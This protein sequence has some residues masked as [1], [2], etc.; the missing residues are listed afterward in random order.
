MFECFYYDD[1]ITRCIT[2]RLYFNAVWTDEDDEDVGLV[3]WANI[4]NDSYDGFGTHR[5]F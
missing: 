5:M 4:E 2:D 3:F 1:G